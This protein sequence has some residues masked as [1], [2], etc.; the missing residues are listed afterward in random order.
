MVKY[1]GHYITFQEVPDEVSLVFA[2]SNCQ[3]S[4]IGCHSPWLREDIGDDLEKDLPELLDKYKEAITC[5]CFMGEGNDPD[6]LARCYRMV[7][8]NCLKTAIYSGIDITRHDLSEFF[9]K[10]PDDFY[11]DYLKVG[12]YK[13]E[14]GGLDSPT[15][16]QR[17]QKI[18]NSDYP[19]YINITNKFTKKEIGQ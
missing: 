8:N 19:I 15:T 12:S 11:P 16:N 9:L 18:F 5:V 4:C 6:A 10:Y 1:T 3:G 7:K 2:I 17:M 14:L 13:Q